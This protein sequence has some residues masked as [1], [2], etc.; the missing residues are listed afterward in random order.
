MS[1]Q[2][3]PSSS[4]FRRP[5]QTPTVSRCSILRP[6]AAAQQ[7][8]ALVVGQAVDIDRV[9]VGLD[10]DA[11]GSVGTYPAPVNRGVENHLQ[12]SDVF[13]NGA[14]AQC[15]ALAIGV[16]LDIESAQV[17]KADSAERV[18][19]RVG[20]TDVL[21]ARAGLL[22]RGDGLDPGV[23]SIAEGAAVVLLARA[24]TIPLLV[25]EIARSEKRVSFRG[26]PRRVM[27]RLPSR[28]L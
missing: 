26:T 14:V 5:V 10:A 12:D 8:I 4:P 9:F 22:L 21:A 7:S 6:A 25:L 3:R 1:C 13:A 27:L 16:A 19:E 18:S 17:L 15:F 2:R 11:F 28:R 23:E 24:Q 20:H